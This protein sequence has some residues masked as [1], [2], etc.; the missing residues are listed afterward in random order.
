MNQNTRTDLIAFIESIEKFSDNV[1]VRED[2]QEELLA[3]CDDLK[4]QLLKDETIL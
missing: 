4:T 2:V 1:K 3:A